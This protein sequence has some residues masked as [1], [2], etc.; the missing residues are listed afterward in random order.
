M[1]KIGPAGAAAS[2]R[3]ADHR[4]QGPNPRFVH[5]FEQAKLFN[6]SRLGFADY[7]G[8][9]SAE[10]TVALVPVDPKRLPK[11]P[12]G[13][14]YVVDSAGHALVTVDA[15]T[16]LKGRANIE[17]QPYRLPPLMGG[18]VQDLF[19]DA[20]TEMYGEYPE[21]MLTILARDQN[22]KYVQYVPEMHVDSAMGIGLDMALGYG[23][24][25]TGAPIRT[26]DDGRFNVDGPQGQ[27]SVSESVNG[28]TPS[29]GDADLWDKLKSWIPTLGVGASGRRVNSFFARDLPREFDERKSPTSQR[30]V[31]VKIEG[32]GLRHLGIAPG[33]YPG[34][35]YQRFQGLTEPARES[36]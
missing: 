15:F 36:F 20:A 32:N 4:S 28:P 14:D 2:T 34:F 3:I 7:R 6:S 29:A 23:Y 30:P 10:G 13:I 19:M 8:V 31:S 22:G 35:S 33:S 12:P 16:N 25:K 21:V 11:P 18:F 1:A 17:G 9:S 5:T 27:Y 26:D 24:N